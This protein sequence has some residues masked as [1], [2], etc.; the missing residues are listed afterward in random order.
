MRRNLFILFFLFAI[1]TIVSQENNIQNFSTSDG[2]SSISIN[3]IN[4]DEIGYLW[5]ATDKG[6][7]KFDGVNF[8]NYQQEKANCIFIEKNKIYIGL[9]NGLVVIQNNKTSF[10]KSKEILKI[11]SINNKIII[12]TIQ[13]VCELKENYIQPLPINTQIDF[14]IINDITY[15]KKNLFIASNSGLWNIDKVNKPHKISKISNENCSSFLVNNNQ[16]IASTFNNG[17]KIIENNSIIKSIQSSENISSIKAINDEIWIPSKENGIEILDLNNFTFKRKINKY[18]S[19]ISSKISTIFSDNQNSIWIASLNKGLFKYSSIKT[20]NRPNIYIENVL[21]NY[22]KISLNN[23]NL[24]LKPNENNISFS[25]KTIDLNNA[26]KIQYR[27]KLN[28]EF[29]PWNSQNKVDFPELKSGKYQFTIQSKNGN[30]LSKKVS[31]P[32]IIKTPIYKKGWFLILGGIAFCLLLAGI[33]DLYIRKLKKQ[34]QQKVENLKLENHLL[35]LEQKA[36]QL[37]M[38]PHFI[39]NVLNGIKALGNSGN[40][41]ELNTTISQFSKLLRSVLNNSRLEEI[42]L[43]DEI[44]TL[45]NYLFLEQKMNANPFDFNINTSLNNIDSEEIL[46]P[47]MLIQPFI[48][49]SIKHAFEPKTEDAKINISFKVKHKFLYFTI[50]DNGI[51]FYQSKKGKLKSNHQSVALKVTKERIKHL[52]KYNSFSIEEMKDKNEIKGTKVEFKIPL[53]T[54]Y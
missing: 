15:F 44:E 46:I 2:L 35:T 34:N 28:K 7:T 20:T 51:G 53:K 43:H 47:P 31:F 4:Q 10:F 1:I 25:F 37:Q 45:K 8:T 27:Y 38:N 26:R 33:I 22:K 17:V 14:S 5:L 52:S 16:I 50:E 6:Y 41:K 54:D 21:V 3:D 19:A 40:S 30:L 39:F 48:E 24:A 9:K 23:E 13:G 42:S 32:F 36:L 12:A 18:N 49:N 29:T 11:R